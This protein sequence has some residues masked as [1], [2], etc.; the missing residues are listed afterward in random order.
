MQTITLEQADREW[1]RFIRFQFLL[2]YMGEYFILTALQTDGTAH[3]RP[4]TPAG[5]LANGMVRSVLPRD[6]TITLMPEG[7]FA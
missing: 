6:K 1:G 4:V 3:L 2:D 5:R 7:T